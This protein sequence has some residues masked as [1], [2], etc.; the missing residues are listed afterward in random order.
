MPLERQQMPQHMPWTEIKSKLIFGAVSSHHETV[1]SSQFHSVNFIEPLVRRRR[2]YLFK[3]GRHSR[4]RN[5]LF[6]A[7]Q[8]VS[9]HRFP[10]ARFEK[11]SHRAK[12]RRASR[13]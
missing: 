4:S 11:V 9:L 5:F 6:A 2:N 1:L 8:I 7:T 10:Q 13:H 3:R 12:S